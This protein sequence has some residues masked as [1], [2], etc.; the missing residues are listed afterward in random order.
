MKKLAA[1]ADTYYLPV[2]PH[3]SGGP[4]ATLLSVHLAVSIPNFLI[5]EEIE[6]ETGLR[7]AICTHPLKLEGGAFPL[8]AAP[9]IGT[10]PVFEALE[11]KD[12]HRYRP[13]P[14]SG[15]TEPPRH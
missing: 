1:L 3:N 10:V 5:L 15:R 6:P 13:Q 4:I 2:A 12:E 7:D 8:P 9:G 14:P 11:G